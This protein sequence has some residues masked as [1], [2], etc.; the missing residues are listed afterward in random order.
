M[1]LWPLLLAFL[2]G[3]QLIREPVAV[4]NTVTAKSK[5]RA[6][7]WTPRPA[8]TIDSTS[9]AFTKPKLEFD[10]NNTPSNNF[11]KKRSIL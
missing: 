2:A 5:S 6:L 8:K 7:K 1:I 3:A 4:A 9:G 11:M 10:S